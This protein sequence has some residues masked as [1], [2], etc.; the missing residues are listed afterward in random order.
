MAALRSGKL[1]EA[2]PKTSVREVCERW[3]GEARGGIVR[4]RNGSEYKPGTVVAYEQELRLRVYSDLGTAPFYRL[5]RRHVQEHVDRLVARGC[6]PATIGK[7]IAALGVVYSRAIQLDDLDLSPTT[8][9]RLPTVRNGRERF[10]TP[11]EAALLLAAVPERDRGIWA[12]AMYAGLRRGE[13]AALRWADV[14][15]KA[16]TLEV[17]R[18]WHPQH[19]YGETKSR[20][21]RRVPIIAELREHLAAARLRQGLGGE[22]CFA[23]PDARPFRADTFQQRADDAWTAAGL[24]R[25][26][27]HDCRHTFASLAIA[28][29]VNAKAL[30]TYLG[31]STVAITLDR[32]G[33]LMP[34]NE[35]EAA[36][37][38]DAYLR[39][40]CAT[41]GA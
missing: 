23:E 5:R 35:A 30:S 38:L 31:H 20:N 33:H 24:T 39:D 17:T 25:L 16:G 37:L 8:G 27:L 29:G 34:G 36:G 9:V 26:T 11:A 6:S 18:S 22:L 7:T 21:R 2:K 15:L 13:I 1:T 14:D 12:T 28:A 19:G 3:L 4:A 32:Y 40:S 10:A 41:V